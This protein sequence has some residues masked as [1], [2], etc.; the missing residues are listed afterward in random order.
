MSVAGALFA[1]YASASS[2]VPPQARAAGRVR[3]DE[4]GG[5]G[6]RRAAPSGG[7]R[8]RLGGSLALPL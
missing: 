6:S 2:L 3:V 5:R 8:T 7:C 4:L 1:V